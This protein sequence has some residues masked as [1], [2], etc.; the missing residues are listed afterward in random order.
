MI[1]ID[2]YY[3]TYCDCINKIFNQ[4]IKIDDITYKKTNKSKYFICRI[5]KQKNEIKKCKQAF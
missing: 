4:T 3:C 1:T 5:C 2:Y